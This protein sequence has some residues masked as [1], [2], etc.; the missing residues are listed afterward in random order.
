M[1]EK[2]KKEGKSLVE[3][4]T[5]KNCKEKRGEFR[6][7]LP[8]EVMQVKGSGGRERG[9][10]GRGGH[11]ERGGEL[12]GYGLSLLVWANNNRFCITDWFPFDQ[13]GGPFTPIICV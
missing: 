9:R 2:L 7:V 1:K 5:E 3:K 4:G 6:K 10:T 12:Q 8:G 13:R 11:M